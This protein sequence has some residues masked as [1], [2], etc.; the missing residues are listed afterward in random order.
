MLLGCW[1]K[2]VRQRLADNKACGSEEVQLAVWLDYVELDD[3]SDATLGEQPWFEASFPPA[4]LMAHCKV[5]L[6]IF[7]AADRGSVTVADAEPEPE[8]EMDG[9]FAREQQLARQRSAVQQQRQL[10]QEQ[11]AESERRRQQ[12]WAEMQARDEQHELER[13]RERER[14]GERH[15]ERC[16]DP[17]THARTHAMPSTTTQE[18]TDT[19]RR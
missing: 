8:L 9:M 6:T 15:S 1:E 18:V 10:E 13:E 7:Q 17:R 19:R 2:F 14:D 5:A 12:M 16:S 3:G 11:M 4:L